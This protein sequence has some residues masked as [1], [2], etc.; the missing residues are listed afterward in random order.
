MHFCY[1]YCWV[2]I[3]NF[4]HYHSLFN[5]K[6]EREEMFWRESQPRMKSDYTGQ[7]YKSV[8]GWNMKILISH[9][10]YLPLGHKDFPTHF[11]YFWN[12]LLIK[13]KVLVSTSNG[14]N[15]KIWTY[16]INPQ[17]CGH[18]WLQ[19]QLKILIAMNQIVSCLKELSYEQSSCRLC[20]FSSSNVCKYFSKF[21]LKKLWGWQCN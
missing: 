1:R 10:G 21:H 9:P 4:S 14:P 7:K 2:N 20:I 19:L 8:M 18:K 11:I 12:K 17:F 16:F 3:L 13:T 5:T 15:N 6:L